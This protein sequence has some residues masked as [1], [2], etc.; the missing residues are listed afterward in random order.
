MGGEKNV[1]E[2]GDSSIQVLN[3]ETHSKIIFNSI[4]KVHAGAYSV[5]VRNKSGEDSAKVNVK[6]V[7]R[8]GAPEGPIQTTVEGGNV[9]LLW[10]HAK[11]DGGLR[12][13]ITSWRRRTMRRGPGL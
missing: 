4:T 12:L 3:T 13:N 9:T 6:V 10:K 11:D 2:L 7:D 8:P 5:V 1:E